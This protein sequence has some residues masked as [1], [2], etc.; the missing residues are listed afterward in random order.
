MDVDIYIKEK[1]GTRS[2]RVPWLPERIRYKSGDATLISYDIMNKGEVAV[3]TGA[4]LANVSWESLFPGENRTDR[5]MQRGDWAAPAE[6]HKLLEY[7]LANGTR[8]TLMVIGYPINMDVTLE[9]Y[10]ADAA[11]GFGD[12]EYNISFLEYREITITS[13]K[14]TTQS[15]KRTTESTESYTIKTGDTL[16]SIAQ[17]FLG[18]GSKWESI[19]NLN[20][21]IIEST[22][23]KR[24]KAAGINR[25][26]QHGHWIFPGTVI[27]IP[28]AG[29]TTASNKTGATTTTSTSTPT[30]TTTTSSS[31]G[32]QKKYS[33]MILN[34]GETDY[35]GTFNIYVNGVYKYGGKA[36]NY[37]ATLN[38]GDKVQVDLSPKDGHKYM[39]YVNGIGTVGGTPFTMNDTTTVKIKWIK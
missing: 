7:W 9:S 21:D 5:S 6:Y 32:T 10:I 12:L 38:G 25:D 1:N 13:T 27:K 39:M 35:W 20:K 24:W 37:N 31:A 34:E 14:T 11:G 17:R 30:T 16:W 2:I 3:P 8:L 4:G 18:S 29:T 19:Y 22:A 33:L 26:S 23:K 36:K 28:G 15:P